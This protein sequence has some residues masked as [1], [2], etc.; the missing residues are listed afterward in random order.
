[1]DEKSV[2][3]LY[4]YGVGHKDGGHSGR[5]PWGSGDNPK[6][7][8]KDYKTAFKTIKKL[9]KKGGLH[10]SFKNRDAVYNKMRNE[11]VKKQAFKDYLEFSKAL[12]DTIEELAKK[13]GISTDKVVIPQNSPLGAEIY[14]RMNEAKAAGNE[15]CDKYLDEYAEA[16]IKD[17]SYTDSE[18]ARAA[19]RDILIKT[20]YRN[21]LW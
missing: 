18:G 20:G 4:H 3:E 7:Y 8:K 14:K 13:Q 21:M 15:I 11:V 2:N 10:K 9:S 5:Y 12:T 17:I 1:M 6:Q 19:V 16:L